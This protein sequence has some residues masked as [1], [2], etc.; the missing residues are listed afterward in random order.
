MKKNLTILMK[1]L[2]VHKLLILDIVSNKD[3][4]LKNLDDHF[5]FSEWSNIIEWD[6]FVLSGG[7]ALRCVL[8]SNFSSGFDNQDLDFFFLEAQ[9]HVKVMRKN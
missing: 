9:T 8:S 1:I 3:Q 7:S 6:S 2:K 4:F 5:N